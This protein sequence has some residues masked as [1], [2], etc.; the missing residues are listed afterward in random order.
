MHGEF[1]VIAYIRYIDTEMMIVKNFILT[2]S[3][4][5]GGIAGHRG[6]HERSNKVS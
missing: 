4:E 6:P 1:V 2:D 3:P 5:T